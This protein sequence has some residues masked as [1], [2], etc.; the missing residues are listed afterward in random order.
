MGTR[1]RAGP[2][3]VSFLTAV[4]P[5]D[6]T[7]NGGV[8]QLMSAIQTLNTWTTNKL[9]CLSAEG[10]YAAVGPLRRR[11]SHFRGQPVPV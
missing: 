11:R 9:C 3:S 4:A 10:G 7:T 6:E 5:R 1:T 2:V 8:L